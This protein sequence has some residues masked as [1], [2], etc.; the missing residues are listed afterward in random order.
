M[1]GILS[2]IAALTPQPFPISLGPDATLPPEVATLIAALWWP[3]R[4][5][6]ARSSAARIAATVSSTEVSL[7]STKTSDGMRGKSSAHVR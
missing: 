4:Y 6:R 5:R 1:D 7:V 3:P 2:W